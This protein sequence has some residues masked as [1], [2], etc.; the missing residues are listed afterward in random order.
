MTGKSGNIVPYTAEQIEAMRR[1]GE[2]LTDWDMSQEEAMRRRHADDEAP[3]PYPGWQDTIT[4]AL[5][6]PKEQITLRLDRDMLKWFRAR[7]KGYQTLIN[8]VLRGYYE[9]ERRSEGRDSR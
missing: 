1:R 2:G 9:H 7:G 5:P 8:A 3:R 6:E 4:V